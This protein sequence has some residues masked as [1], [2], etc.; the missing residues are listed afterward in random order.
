M[1]SVLMGI[2]LHANTQHRA[3]LIISLYEKLSIPQNLPYLVKCLEKFVDC[4]PQSDGI[5]QPASQFL[6][7]YSILS[8]LLVS[9]EALYTDDAAVATND[10][11]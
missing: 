1:S 8:P 10:L 3:V 9:N 11:F 7:L 6:V 2:S 5:E 4:Y